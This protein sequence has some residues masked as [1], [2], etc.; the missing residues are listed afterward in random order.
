MG[1]A[2]HMLALEP[3]RFNHNF[4]CM[5]EEVNLTT[6]IGKEMYAE[7]EK[8]A[9]GRDILRKSDWDDIQIMAEAIKKHSIWGNF[10][11]PLIEQS[12]FWDGGIGGTRLRA[13]PDVFNDKVIID[14]KTTDS[15]SG[16]QRSLHSY[17]YHRQAAMQIDGLYS[18]D[19]KERH[20]AF[21]VVEKKAP[22]L[23]A[24]FE[25]DPDSIAYGREQYIDGAAKYSE[26]MATGVWPG[27]SELV[28]TITLPSWAKKT[29]DEIV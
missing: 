13:R 1:R 27:Y 10:K 7:A 28:Q 15:I 21:F 12:I 11:N 2:V 4:Y 16:F 26:C 9:Q 22:H 17:G 25:L 23:T 29:E 24:I 8:K 18:L 5:N 6:K 14:I 3:D 19:K 20:F